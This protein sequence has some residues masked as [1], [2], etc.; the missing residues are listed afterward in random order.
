MLLAISLVSL[1]C[2]I[3]GAAFLFAIRR[4]IADMSV[5]QLHQSE[6]LANLNQNIVTAIASMPKKRKPREA[7]EES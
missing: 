3:I 7:S 2:S 4:H 6:A 5:C 1:L